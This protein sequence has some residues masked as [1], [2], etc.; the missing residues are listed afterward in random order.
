MQER[1]YAKSNVKNAFHLKNI[2]ASREGRN[3]YNDDY[4]QNS[5][6]PSPLA[7]HARAHKPFKITCMLNRVVSMN[8][9]H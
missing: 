6:L 1:A 3:D 9:I 2:A 5:L 8:T 4:K 7:T